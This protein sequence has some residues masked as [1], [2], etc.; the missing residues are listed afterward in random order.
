MDAVFER[1]RR[2]G[3]LLGRAPEEAKLTHHP[4]ENP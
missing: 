2:L 4:Q 1:N 3:L